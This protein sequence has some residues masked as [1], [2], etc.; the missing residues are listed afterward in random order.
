MSDQAISGFLD[1]FRSNYSGER[2]RYL[3]MMACAYCF[4]T[5]ISPDEVALVETIEHTDLGFTITFHYARR[6][7]YLVE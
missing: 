6:E 4:L 1:E 3:E 2:G 5:G 7:D